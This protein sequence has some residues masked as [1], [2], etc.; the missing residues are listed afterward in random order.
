MKAGTPALLLPQS[1]EAAPLFGRL[2]KGAEEHFILPESRGSNTVRRA[3]GVVREEKKKKERE[4]RRGSWS[5]S[6]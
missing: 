5:S 6:F 1:S 2:R 3:E 4:K